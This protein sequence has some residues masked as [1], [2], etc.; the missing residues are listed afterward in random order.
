MSPTKKNKFTGKKGK[1]LSFPFYWI[2]DECARSKG[3]KWP[4][5]H[6]ATATSGMCMYCRGENQRLSNTI[7]PYVDY[8]WPG[9]DTS[10]GR[11]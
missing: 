4:K 8:D 6:V 9:L 10:S 7:I 2:C 11:D 3:G 1:K 5:G